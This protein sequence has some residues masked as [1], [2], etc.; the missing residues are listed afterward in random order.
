MKSS[1]RRP[2]VF[3]LVICTYEP[4]L[5]RVV[6][7][8]HPR[9]TYLEGAWQRL[10]VGGVVAGRRTVGEPVVGEPV[11]GEPAVGELAA[12]R[13][14]AGR[15]FV[16]LGSED[17]QVGIGIHGGCK[18]LWIVGQQP[19]LRGAIVGLVPCYGFDCPCARMASD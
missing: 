8:E 6:G 12:G 5:I 4:A 17:S 3:G 2:G 7:M 11:V 18:R 10:E 13:P 19:A 9:T 1:V 16:L 15:Q 14:A